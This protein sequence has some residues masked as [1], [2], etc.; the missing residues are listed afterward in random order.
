MNQ[1]SEE[2]T[3]KFNE[4]TKKLV[5]VFLTKV[6]KQC[7]DYDIQFK[8]VLESI[9][10]NMTITYLKTYSKIEDKTELQI[11]SEFSDRVI[12]DIS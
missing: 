6:N 5:T 2:V 1:V 8:E 11:F 7:A 3:E 9:L 4:E 12:R 10:L